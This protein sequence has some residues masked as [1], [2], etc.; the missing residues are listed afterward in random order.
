MKLRKM[1]ES[2]G[3]QRLGGWVLTGSPPAPLT[4]PQQERQGG[5][6]AP[7]DCRGGQREPNDIPIKAMVWGSIQPICIES[8][9]LREVL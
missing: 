3:S 2:P 4:A 9:A 7:P 5:A 8:V 6:K 1:K